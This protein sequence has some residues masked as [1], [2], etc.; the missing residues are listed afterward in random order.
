[1]IAIYRRLNLLLVIASESS[2]ANGIKS[3]YKQQLHFQQSGSHGQKRKT[4]DDK[5]DKV[6]EILKFRCRITSCDKS[7][8][9]NTCK[10]GAHVNCTCPKQ[11]RI[12]KTELKL[13]LAQRQR[14]TAPHKHQI[15]PVDTKT[16]SLKDCAQEDM[17]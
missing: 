8:C 5:L 1:M 7:E 9:A 12:P 4:F 2:I 15:T 11:E 13:F 3:A 6:L 14:G 17:L 10:W 16:N